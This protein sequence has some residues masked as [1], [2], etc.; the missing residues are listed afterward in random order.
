MPPGYRL[1]GEEEGTMQP[2]FTTFT[3]AAMGAF[4][5]SLTTANQERRDFMN[6]T[7]ES[8]N[9][10]LDAARR[11]RADA[12]NE[13]QNRASH[14]AGSRRMFM[15]TLRSDVNTMTDQFRAHREEIANDLRAM[16]E[17]LRA[18]QAAYHNGR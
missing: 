4:R 16:G 12:E 14:D 8:T 11:S 10:L 2:H 9:A 1:T 15:E 17:E 3:A 13:R 7:R 5:D 6:R 18:A